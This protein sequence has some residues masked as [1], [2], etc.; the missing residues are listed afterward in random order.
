MTPD[1]LNKMPV[2]EEYSRKVAELARMI[3]RLPAGRREQPGAELESPRAGT[4]LESLRAGLKQLRRGADG[5]E[6]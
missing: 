2:D 6:L 3:E 4:V 5:G 1:N